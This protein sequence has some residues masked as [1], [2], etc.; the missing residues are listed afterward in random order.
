MFGERGWSG[1][2]LVEFTTAALRGSD[3][4]VVFIN[5]VYE[6]DELPTWV[7]AQATSI[8]PRFGDIVRFDETDQSLEEVRLKEAAKRLFPS[9]RFDRGSILVGQPWMVERVEHSF[10]SRPTPAKLLH[11]VSV[12]VR[13]L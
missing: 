12:I 9:S 2:K 8:I 7:W 3:E 5:E 11:I 1:S 6:A 4:L 13:E 10:Y